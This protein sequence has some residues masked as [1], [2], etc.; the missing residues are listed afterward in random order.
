[1]TEPM[2]EALRDKMLAEERRVAA[3]VLKPRGIECRRVLLVGGAGYIGTPLTAALLA[4]GYEVRCLDLLLYQNRECVTPFLGHP[5]YGFILGDLADAATT[6]AAL[7]SITDVIVLAGLVGDPITKKYPREHQAI[8][9]DGL[10]RLIDRL[11][12]RGL[13]K[14]VMVST[15]S[16]YGAIP[17]NALADEDYPL[18]PLSLYARAKV[19][20][21][22]Q[23]LGGANKV[24]YSATV[25]RFATAFGLSARMRFDLTVSEF[26]RDLFSGAVLQVYD[27]DTWRPYCHVRD[28]ARVLTRVLEMPVRDVGFE[29]FNAGGDA[30]NYTKKMIAEA[31]Q[32]HFPQSRFELVDRGDED[33]RNYKVDFSKIRTRLHFEPQFSVEQGVVELIAALRQGFFSDYPQRLNFYRNNELQYFAT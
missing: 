27:A 4:R 1:M 7:D 32:R 15:C 10:A 12:G 19:A 16:N 18:K 22:K 33:R 8:N 3:E 26:T 20:R 17:T 11:D 29:V 21:E 6:E 13:N 24:D 30:N 2:P 28:F 5:G 14:V 25:L 23:V 9:E 31:V